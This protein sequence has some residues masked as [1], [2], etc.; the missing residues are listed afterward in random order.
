MM[1]YFTTEGASYMTS[2]N[3]LNRSYLMN[4]AVPLIVGLVLWF[5]PWQP[6]AV[7]REGWQMFAIFVATI[8]GIIMKSLP[9]GAVAIIGMTIAG[10][11]RTIEIGTALGGF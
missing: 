3:K 7:P 8:V 2:E 6:A 9:M 1:N 10:F 4:W 5:F 11:T